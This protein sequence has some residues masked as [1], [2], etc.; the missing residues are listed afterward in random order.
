MIG[1]LFK[2]A[3]GKIELDGRA[4]AVDQALPL[5]SV[6]ANATVASTPGA[7][8]PAGGGST[9]TTAGNDGLAPGIYGPTT[10]YAEA[11]G[12]TGA[13]LGSWLLRGFTGVP[14]TTLG[15][16]DTATG[17]IYLGGLNGLTAYTSGL[18]YLATANQ[19]ASYSYVLSATD[20]VL[21]KTLGLTVLAKSA[22]MLVAN[23]ILLDSSPT[24]S[25]YGQ[26]LAGSAFVSAHT[27]VGTTGAVTLTDP[28]GQFRIDP[29][30]NI[31]TQPGAALNTRYGVYPVTL[32]D[33]G[34]ASD[35][36]S[37]VIA[38]E[39]V[40]AISF[41]G[42][43]AYDSNPTLMPAT[44]DFLSTNAI[45]GQIAA[46]SEIGV[47]S[48]SID[49][50]NLTASRSGI[51]YWKSAPVAGSGQSFNATVV[52]QSG[53]SSVLA[54]PY[55][56]LPGTILPPSNIK[57]TLSSSLDNTMNAVVVGT[58][59]VSGMT[60][61]KWSINLQGDEAQ[62]L[63]IGEGA[64]T[65]RYAITATGALSAQI[66]AAYLS[67]QTDSLIIDALGDNGV[68]CTAV[69]P[70]VIAAKVGPT[71]TIG[72]ASDG[73]GA[74]YNFA[75][76]NA[77]LDAYWGNPAVYGGIVM[78]AFPQ[79]YSHDFT[80]VQA[81]HGSSQQFA[82][83][84]GTLKG[85]SAANKTLL[86][87]K[88]GAPGLGAQGG[89]IAQNYDQTFQYLDIRNVTNINAGEGNAGGI[90]KTNTTPGNLTILDCSLCNCDINVMNGDLGNHLVMARVWTAF[91]GAGAGGL[92]HNI[93]AGHYS[94]A[95][96]T[97][98][99]SFSTAQVHELKSRAG[100]N[101]LLR[102]QMLDGENG[103]PGGSGCL[104]L[105]CGGIATV[106]NC[107]FQKGPN[108]NGDGNMLQFCAE[109][110]NGGPVLG[111]WPSNTLVVSGCKFL[112]TCGPGA[113][114]SAVIGIAQSGYQGVPY[115]SIVTD[116]LA[117]VTVSNTGFYNLP[118]SQWFV[119]YQG[120]AT[121]IDGGGN[122]A[123]TT[124]PG[125]Q[126]IDPSTNA[127]IANPPSPTYN[128]YVGNSYQG[129]L[130]SPLSLELRAALGAAVGTA[131]DTVIA[132]GESGLLL[133][134]TSFQILSTLLVTS[135][136]SSGTA[137]TGV[138]GITNAGALTVAGAVQDGLYFIHVQGAGT[139]PTT[140]GVS[141]FTKWL[142]IVGGPGT[143][144]AA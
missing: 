18:A 90:Y 74:T 23:N 12:G 112:N 76:W 3:T 36:T 80:H 19:K 109:I 20:G 51:V 1:H 91:G 115:R 133:T 21:T 17:A 144:A 62:L 110:G 29:Y 66:T 71:V 121:P 26:Q 68:R 6:A 88:G 84:P 81:G 102:V 116:A 25:W 118:K 98:L 83:G 11:G 58:V 136:G 7:G 135:A 2:D 108:P 77:A 37:L 104:D 93:Y 99:L 10:I 27:D 94:S 34:S 50:V 28:A 129:L 41:V 137:V 38:A 107:T 124:W 16:P 75:T 22:V 141:T 130:V 64:V 48:I 5:A 73:T 4:L 95:T 54:V 127:L 117:T 113:L 45:F 100:R 57:A 24:S 140:K 70:L 103:A 61:P 39:Q 139:D 138:F 125:L 67:G 59:S 101:T 55:T 30:N 63:G 13:A 60:N 56:I 47:A 42:V 9:S 65:P 106:T 92:T 72:S 123:I 78:M 111:N 119:G 86:D 142:F 8:A 105:P 49:A 132:C 85:L 79:D 97:D 14:T 143:V 87:F 126:A 35:A 40:P 134:S 31:V 131:I 15:G 69:V 46:Y 89:L 96:F 32:K 120:G 53:R 43:Q 52:S 114:S 128:R 33:A 122:Y 44:Q 82:P